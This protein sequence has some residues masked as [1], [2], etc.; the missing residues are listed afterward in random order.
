MGHIHYR[1]P[2]AAARNSHHSKDKVT[3]FIFIVALCA[4]L[5]ARL[6]RQTSKVT[7]LFFAHPCTPRHAAI[8]QA[9][10][11]AALCW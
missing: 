4:P 10:G 2:F 8:P 11:P 1:E 9:V 5:A 7:G 6:N 3:G